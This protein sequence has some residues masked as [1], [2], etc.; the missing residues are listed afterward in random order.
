MLR[1]PKLFI[2]A[3]AAVLF[4]LCLAW[5]AWAQEKTDKVTLRTLMV[6]WYASSSAGVKLQYRD[7]ENEPH[8]LYLPAKF[9]RKY[10]R[11]VEAPKNYGSMSGL[12]ILLIHMKGQEILFVDLYTEYMRKKARMGNFTQDDLDKFK[13]AEQKGKVEIVFE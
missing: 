6:D 4:V 9:E 10:F 7:F 5:G 3:A 1:K 11:F 12:P 13:E 8:L 2:A